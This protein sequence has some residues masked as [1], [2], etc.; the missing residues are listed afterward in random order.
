MA[1]S[2]RPH[3]REAIDAVKRDWAAGHKAVLG[4]A[5][6]GSGK[7]QIALGLLTEELGQRGGRALFLAQ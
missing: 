1:C 4:V 6:T 7:T 3:Q 2:L 5:A